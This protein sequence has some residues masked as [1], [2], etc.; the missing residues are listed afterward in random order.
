MAG[1]T[2]DFTVAV[3]VAFVVITNDV[4]VLIVFPLMVSAGQSKVRCTVLARRSLWLAHGSRDTR[5]DVG[6]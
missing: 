1:E 4:P 5:S 2:L 6:R 3:A